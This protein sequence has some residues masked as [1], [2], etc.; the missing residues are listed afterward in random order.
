MKWTVQC[1]NLH[2]TVNN[3]VFCWI[4]WGKRNN[5]TR[6]FKYMRL[7]RSLSL[8][9]PWDTIRSVLVGLNATVYWLKSSCRINH[10]ILWSLYTINSWAVG[11]YNKKRGRLFFNFYFNNYVIKCNVLGYQQLKQVKVLSESVF[12]VCNWIS[13]RCYIQDRHYVCKLRITR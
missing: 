6:K 9:R 12:S 11:L 10:T 1:K 3:T 4:S 13:K 2:L 7:F 8:K 5:T